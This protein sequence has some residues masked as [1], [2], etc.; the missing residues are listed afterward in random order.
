MICI[1]KNIPIPPRIRSGG[2]KPKY[3]WDTVEIGDSFLLAT[4]NVDSAHAQA[5]HA[6]VRYGIKLSVR[7]TNEGYR[8]WRIA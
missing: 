1:D 5:G 8:V 3:P 4:S 2:R 6:A 7:K